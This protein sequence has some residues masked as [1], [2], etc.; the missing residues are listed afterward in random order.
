MILD[1]SV[2]SFFELLKGLTPEQRDAEIKSFFGKIEYRCANYDAVKD[3]PTVES[4]DD[5]FSG[6]AIPTEMKEV[7]RDDSIDID[8][9]MRPAWVDKLPNRPKNPNKYPI[10][11]EN[12]GIPPGKEGSYYEDYV[13]IDESLRP[14]WVYR[15]PNKP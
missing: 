5:E 4:S 9:D 7:F 12:D 8:E 10:T 15:L 11:A 3:Q 6:D 2:L 1:N 13:D 14:A